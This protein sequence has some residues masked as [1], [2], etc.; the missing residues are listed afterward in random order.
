MFLK[1]CTACH[2]PLSQNNAQ[3]NGVTYC[4]D[5]VGRVLCPVNRAYRP[6][7]LSV[8]DCRNQVIRLLMAR[9]HHRTTI[10]RLMDISS[11]RLYQVAYN[12]L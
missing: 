6:G 1:Q 4:P 9:G 5:H 3:I 10:S 12:T 11:Q 2:R 7:L 8:N